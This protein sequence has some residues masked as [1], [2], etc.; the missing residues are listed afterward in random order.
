MALMAA[1]VTL[2]AVALP[3]LP[4][5]LVVPLWL[6]LG[7]A[8]A[9]PGAANTAVA[10]GHALKTMRT[11]HPLHRLRRGGLVRVTLWGAAG[12]LAVAVLLVRL[13]AGGA[14]GWMGAAAGVAAVVAVMWSGRGMTARLHAPVHADARLRRHAL[15]AGTAAVVVVS[16]LAG[17]WLGPGDPALT[18]PATSALIAEAFEA[19]RLWV[20]VEAWAL[21]AVTALGLLPPMAEAVLA[22][23]L[24]GVSGGAVAAL[25]V[26]ALMQAQDWR[27]A[28]ATSSDAQE[29][30]PA[31]PSAVLAV[32]T[33][34]VLVLAGAFW[35]ERQLFPHPPEARPMAQLQTTA[36]ERIGTA[37]YPAGTHA[38]VD[39]GRATLAAQDAAA[40]AELRTAAEAGFDAMLAGVDPFL[41]GY[42]SL[43]GEYWRMGVAVGGWVRGDPEAAL[44]AHLAGRL[45]DALDSD[46]H[47]GP[48]TERLALLSLAE[49][50][51]QQAARETALLGTALSDI[52]PAR[53]RVEASFPALAPLP[54]LRS[55][56]LSSNLE[57]RLGGSVAMGVLGAVVAR[58]VLQRLVQ[59]GILRLGARALLATVPLVGT[60]L[61]VGTDVAALKLEEHYNRADFRA[62]IVAALEEQRASFIAAIAAPSED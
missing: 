2:A 49:A 34:T 46:T 50:R 53:L 12:I 56:G 48:V 21:G 13:S 62:E 9:V 15:L 45:N 16:G 26:A 33:L 7:L 28:V 54:E 10:R 51:A 58:R 11:A 29:P 43:R 60:A 42:Y 40:L 44:E 52:N 39:A 17:W 5:I 32:S 38:E 47:L 18:R 61:A 4:L 57:T 35:S 31:P 22:A 41:D 14:P 20:G 25:A 1:G 36:A 8:A 30:P 3:R 19:Q 6:T 37:Y 55:L 59:R 27:R 24:L 23:L